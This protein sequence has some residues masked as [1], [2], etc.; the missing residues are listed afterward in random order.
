MNKKLKTH[1]IQ[2]L[3]ASNRVLEKALQKRWQPARKPAVWPVGPQW[4]VWNSA[5]W[6]QLGGFCFFFKTRFL[7]VA[8]GCPRTCCVNSQSA[9]IK[10]GRVTS[11]G[12]QLE[13]SGWGS[14][15]RASLFASL[16]AQACLTVLQIL[17]LCYPN[18]P[19]ILSPSTDRGFQKRDI[20]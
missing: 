6:S 8:P 2:I 9:M 3:K 7:S 17:K 16:L 18:S 4:H 11:A 13:S 14:S 15:P 1:Q 5:L 19:W 12:P 20:C 10:G